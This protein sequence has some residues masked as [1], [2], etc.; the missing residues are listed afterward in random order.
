MSIL[1]AALVAASILAWTLAVLLYHEAQRTARLH[2]ELDALYAYADELA[3]L[4]LVAASILAWT[5]AEARNHLR[6]QP[7]PR[8]T[9]AR[10]AR[11]TYP[12]PPLRNPLESG[13]SARSAGAVRLA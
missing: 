5:L 10:N 11:H 1:L 4:A 6:T 12:A 8:S 7:P 3:D 13:V 2:R 9:Q